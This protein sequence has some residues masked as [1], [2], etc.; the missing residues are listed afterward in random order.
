[1]NSKSIQYVR[2]KA[3]D[4]LE[5]SGYILDERYTP[6]IV[7]NVGKISKVECKLISGKVITIS[8]VRPKEFT[9]NY[10]SIW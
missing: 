3:R 2:S 10:N 9:E 6:R 8:V 5:S 4:I 7:N 1:M